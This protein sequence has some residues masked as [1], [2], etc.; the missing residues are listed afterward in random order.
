[1]GRRLGDAGPRRSGELR[2]LVPDDLHVSVEDPDE[3]VGLEQFLAEPG[4]L[5][6]EGL[7]AAGTLIVG[8][9]ALRARL[10]PRD[11]VEAVLAT[12]SLEEGVE[13]ADL[14]GGR[15]GFVEA[16]SIALVEIEVRLALLGSLG[17]Y[18][19]GRF[20]IKG[21]EV[22]GIGWHLL[23]G[24]AQVGAHASQLARLDP[25]SLVDVLL[26]V[27]RRSR[28]ELL[29]LSS[30]VGERLVPVCGVLRL[31]LTRGGREES[32]F[33]EVPVGLLLPSL[34]SRSLLRR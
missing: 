33:E 22:K 2:E 32:L 34:F 10:L 12:M 30:G 4:D 25:E 18:L 6:A 1:M 8:Q 5:A 15:G 7:E 19:P 28:R 31:D 16:G 20:G 29:H 21:E 27:L 24:L 3:A 26:V 17:V 14:L 13:L 9:T 11:G 23:G